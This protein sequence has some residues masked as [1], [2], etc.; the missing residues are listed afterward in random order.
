MRKTCVSSRT[1]GRAAVVSCIVHRL[2]EGTQEIAVYRSEL[3]DLVAA[4]LR[5]AQQETLPKDEVH[6]SPTHLWVRG[7]L[8]VTRMPCALRNKMN[9]LR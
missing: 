9:L 1:D 8:D 6:V 4:V 3:D 5:Y 2:N 7:G